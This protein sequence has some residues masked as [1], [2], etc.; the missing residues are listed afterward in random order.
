[1]FSPWME[2]YESA[3][4]LCRAFA[5]FHWESFSMEVFHESLMS[6]LVTTAPCLAFEGDTLSRGLLVDLPFQELCA[7]AYL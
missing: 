2:Q 1:L 5:S 7:G 6:L 3:C 4:F